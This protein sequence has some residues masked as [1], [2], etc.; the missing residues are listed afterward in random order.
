MII[1]LVSAYHSA[2]NGNTSEIKSTPRGQGTDGSVR[3]L[4]GRHELSPTNT[5][6]LESLFLALELEP[7]EH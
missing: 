4:L 5:E 1:V 7:A 2:A 6:V 3:I